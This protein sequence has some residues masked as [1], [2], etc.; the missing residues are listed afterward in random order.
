MKGSR[1]S[2]ERLDKKL[3]RNW[4]DNMNKTTG[5][6]FGKGHKYLVLLLGCSLV[7]VG[8]VILNQDRGMQESW[9]EEGFAVAEVSGRVIAPPVDEAA[10]YH[11][12]TDYYEVPLELLA[13]P[14][15]EQVSDQPAVAQAESEEKQEKKKE[16]ASTYVVHPG[17]SLW[18]IARQYGLR[19][20]DLAA[21]NGLSTKQFIRPGQKL[22]I[23]PGAGLYHIVCPG[24]SLWNICRAYRVRLQEVLAENNIKDATLIRPGQKLFL[25][26]ARKK[27]QDEGFSWPLR[28]RLTSRFGY[29]QHPMGGGEKFHAGID[30]AAPVSRIIRAARDGKV[31][32]SGWRGNLGRTVIL[33]HKDGY[34]TVYGHNSSLIVKAG[35]RVQQGQAISRVGSTG[36]STGPHLHFEIRKGSKAIDPLILLP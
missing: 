33:Q 9:I 26:G 21:S 12:P 29:R 35:Q 5:Q 23:P 4:L 11:N 20:M 6:P 28:G 30:I 2:S 36:R 25:P 16:K 13:E 10:F 8:L 1:L 15:E 7:L 27:R 22:M 3:P 32:F 31:I 19:V 34:R 24:E 17:D 18:S 14:P